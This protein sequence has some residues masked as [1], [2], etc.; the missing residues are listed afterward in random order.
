MGAA[1]GTTLVLRVCVVEA[2]KER[3]HCLEGRW[4]AWVVRTTWEKRGRWVSYVLHV[5]GGQS[6]LPRAGRFRTGDCVE[7]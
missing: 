6:F 7:E 2:M 3:K 1:C 5:S 4:D